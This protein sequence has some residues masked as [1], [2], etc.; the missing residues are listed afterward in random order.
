M[1]QL[2]N[3]YGMNRRYALDYSGVQSSAVSRFFNIVYAWM[4]AGLGVT[5]VVAL[6]VSQ[7]VQKLIAAQDAAALRQLG[8]IFIGLLVAQFVLVWVISAATQRINATVATVLFLVYS[9]IMG[10]TFAGLFMVYTKATLASAFVITAG[11]FGAMSVFGMVTKRDLTF[12]GRIMIMGLIG[13][14]IAS[15]V[16]IF[17]HNTM[18]QVAMNYLGVL[19]FVGLTAYDT[20]KLK[21]IAEQTEG[22]PAL[23]ARL[24]ISGSL[25]LYLDFINLFLFILRLMNDRRN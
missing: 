19:V 21:I 8:P 3:P 23:A 13:L 4:S 12:M 16:S 17:W 25:M 20:Q 14:V 2:P 1:A 22:N 9:A 7:Y 24:A 18:L 11:T 5:A 15:I 10:V 6:L